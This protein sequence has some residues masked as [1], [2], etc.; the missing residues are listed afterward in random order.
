M[1]HK[2]KQHRR[3]WRRFGSGDAHKISWIFRKPDPFVFGRFHFLWWT[4]DKEH[5][6]C[7]SWA[8]VDDSWAKSKAKWAARGNSRGS[9]VA[10][11]FRQHFCVSPTMCFSA[12]AKQGPCIYQFPSFRFHYSQVNDAPQFVHTHPVL[13]H[14]YGHWST[15]DCLKVRRQRNWKDSSTYFASATREDYQHGVSHHKNSTMQSQP[16]VKRWA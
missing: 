15:S 14:W 16:W 13:A 1:I 10:F 8:S 4:A 2:N 5:R 12:G 3:Q 6:I 7:E 9:F 11:W